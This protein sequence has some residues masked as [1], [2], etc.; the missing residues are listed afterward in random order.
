MYFAIYFIALCFMAWCL[1]QLFNYL[2]TMIRLGRIRA[3]V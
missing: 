2:Y 1:N 3:T